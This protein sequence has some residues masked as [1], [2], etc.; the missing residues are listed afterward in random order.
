V[1][2]LVLDL[3][4]EA[5]TGEAAEMAHGISL[6]SWIA[7][8]CRH[9]PTQAG[10]LI[11]Q[12]K[13]RSG[14]PQVCEAGRTGEVNPHQGA[15]IVNTLN[16]LP[17]ELPTTQLVEGEATMIRYAAQFDSDGLSRLGNHLVEV[18]APEVADEVNRNAMDRQE[19]LAQRDRHLVFTND[20]HGSVF[21]RG[22][23]P[24]LTAEPLIRI[25]E[26]YS[27]DLRRKAIDRL[28]PFAETLTPGMRRADALVTL[29]NAHAQQQLA[30][31][32]GGDRPRVVVTI[33]Y[34]RLLADCSKAKL[35][36]GNTTLTAGQLRQIA[37]DADI[38]PAVLGGN[39]EVLDVGREKRL[40][41]PPI[42]LA[43]H[44]R[45]RG[46][47]FP[48]CDTPPAACHAHHLTPWWAGGVT[49]LHNLVLV[50]PHH[51]GIVEPGHD[52]NADRWRIRLDQHG[53][54]EVIPPKRVD[55]TGIPRRHQR[56]KLE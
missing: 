56:Y 21:I 48:G 27:E 13:A 9:T 44:L 55:P 43:L 10:S 7:D 52:P 49:A 41:T 8:R 6:R 25:I 28:D 15:A 29:V 31:S 1:Q 12:A 37:C 24:V 50:C 39:S 22:Q 20:G 51:H 46:C 42:R 14:F 30:P 16:R 33:S 19:R 32:V 26:A 3:V 45:D 36:D 38:L 34:D 35:I 17:V 47:A 40:V 23:L 4:G 53:Q 54:P 2:A 11:H 5:K 18:I